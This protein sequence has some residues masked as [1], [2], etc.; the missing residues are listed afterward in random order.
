MFVCVGKLVFESLHTIDTFTK[1]KFVT[2][3]CD[4][5]CKQEINRIL[6]SGLDCYFEFG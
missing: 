4:T 6:L 2:K 1:K 5:I 3:H